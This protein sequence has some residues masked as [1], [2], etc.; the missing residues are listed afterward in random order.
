MVSMGE[1]QGGNLRW[2]LIGREQ[3]RVAGR[4]SKPLTSQTQVLSPTVRR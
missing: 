4:E 2:Y 1:R 3:E